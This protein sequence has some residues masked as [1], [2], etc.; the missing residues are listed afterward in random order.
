MAAQDTSADPIVA[1]VFGNDNN[2]G[3]ESIFSGH[4]FENGRTYHSFSAGKYAF[5]NDEREAERLD[6]QHYLFVLAFRGGISLSPKA[7]TA[8]RVLDIGTG[9]GAWAI[10]YGK[11]AFFLTLNSIRTNT[12]PADA[13]PEAEVIGVDPSPIQPAW[14]PP[15]LQ[16]VI[17]DVEQYWAWTKPFDYISSRA[18]AGSFTN[19][20]TVIRKAFA[21]LEP[22]GVL[23]M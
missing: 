21:A 17:D 3:A 1:D 19:P 10:D 11:T 15:N 23:E 4:Q 14:V 2:D 7:S 6:I 20:S 8:K 9:T 12:P 22:G 16:F 13:Y 5:P 18:M